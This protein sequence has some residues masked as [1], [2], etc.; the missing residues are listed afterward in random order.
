MLTAG[1]TQSQTEYSTPSLE[2]QRVRIHDRDVDTRIL[3]LTAIPL[4]DGDAVDQAVILDHA[5]QGQTVQHCSGAFIK[6]RTGGLEPWCIGFDL[7]VGGEVP[8]RSGEAEHKG[9]TD[10]AINGFRD[11]LLLGISNDQFPPW[12]ERLAGFNQLPITTD[13][14]A[15]LWG[16][17]ANGLPAV[18]AVHCSVR[19]RRDLPSIICQQY[20]PCFMMYSW[21]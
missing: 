5:R 11:A 20:S 15:A 14:F 13:G 3:V 19:R 12:L 17:D 21:V 9:D 6:I 1:A 4:V 8:L 7:T 10:R 16:R 2:G 18:R